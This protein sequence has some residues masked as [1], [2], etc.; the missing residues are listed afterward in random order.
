M[1][2]PFP[3]HGRRERL[4]AATTIYWDRYHQGCGV[5]LAEHALRLATHPMTVFA[6]SLQGRRGH[7]DGSSAGSKAEI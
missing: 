3:G 7:A 1:L 6:C 5:S 2:E 4:Q